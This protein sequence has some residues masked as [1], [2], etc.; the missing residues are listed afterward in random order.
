MNI[1][2][3]SELAAMAQIFQRNEVIV[4]G[5]TTTVYGGS[6]P[7]DDPAVADDLGGWKI[8]K[9][10]IVRNGGV[11]TTQQLWAV[12]TEG[13]TKSWANRARLDYKYL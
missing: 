5:D 6:S 3:F 7:H 11:T 8:Q 4:D 2:N 12:E 9:V 1:I 10:I 13:I